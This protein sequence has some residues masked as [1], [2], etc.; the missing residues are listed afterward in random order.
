MTD[1]ARVLFDLGRITEATDRLSASLDSIEASGVNA[2]TCSM[3][4]Q[5]A[6]SLHRLGRD[7]EAVPH[8]DRAFIHAQTLNLPQ[9]LA[10]AFQTR[11]AILLAQDRHIEALFSVEAAV[12]IAH[13]ND[14]GYEEGNAHAAAAIIRQVCG[15]PGVE[16]HTIAALATARRRGDRAFE[17]W[18]SRTS[19]STC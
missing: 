3:S 6:G 9:V 5:L 14:L 19:T 1:L 12:T 2:A 18:R 8:L 17:P 10:S 4:A 7:E 16:A 13:D 15:L 11:A